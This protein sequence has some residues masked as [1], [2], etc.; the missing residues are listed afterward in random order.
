MYALEEL[1]KTEQDYINDLGLLVNG[2]MIEINNEKSD[3]PLPD[4]LKDN[5]YRRVF[6]NIEA[7]YEFHRE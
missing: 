3:V 6:A 7:I 2:Y 5:N 1:I 4:D